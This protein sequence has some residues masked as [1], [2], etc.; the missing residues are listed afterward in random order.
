MSLFGDISPGIFKN[1]TRSLVLYWGSVGRS[2]NYDAINAYLT[3]DQWW[4]PPGFMTTASL[5][6]PVR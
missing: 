4:V 6:E 3:L 5:L 1:A 2:A